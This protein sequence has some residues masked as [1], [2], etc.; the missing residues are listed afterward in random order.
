MMM[1]TSSRMTDLSVLAADLTQPQRLS[2]TVE[3]VNTTLVTHR[4]YSAHNGA[5]D[6]TTSALTQIATTVSS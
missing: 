3:C 2:L 1:M 5:S 4:L 6:M